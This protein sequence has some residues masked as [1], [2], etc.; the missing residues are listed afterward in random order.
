MKKVGVATVWRNVDGADPIDSDLP[1][2]TSEGSNDATPN[3][4][5]FT[6]NQDAA[7]AITSCG[8]SYTSSRSI[9]FGAPSR[10]YNGS[11]QRLLCK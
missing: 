2:I 9:T 10:F 3:A 4:P 5:D 6:T 7:M 11:I 1:V 8:L